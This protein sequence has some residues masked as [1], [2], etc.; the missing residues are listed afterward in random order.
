MKI[1]AI[2]RYSRLMTLLVVVVALVA[3]ACGGSS[4]SWLAAG[5]ADK[6]QPTPTVEA[7]TEP[8]LAPTAIATVTPTPTVTATPQPTA[9]PEPTPEFRSTGRPSDAGPTQV[10]TASRDVGEIFAYD[11]PR[12]NRIIPQYEYLNGGSVD[13]PLT[14]ST[15]WTHYDG[16]LSMHVVE[17]DEDDDWIKVLLPIRPQGSSAWIENENVEWSTSDHYVQINVVTNSVTVWDGDEIILDGLPVVTGSSNTP[18]PIATSYIDEI[19][20]SPS[21]VLGPWTL[22]LALFSESH[23]KFSGALPKIA[24]HGWNDNSVMGQNLSNGCIRFPNDKIRFLAEN[25]PV[26]TRVDIIST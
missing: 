7:V 23:N 5:A 11:A 1:R 20:P 13:Y 14:T 17:G 6:I 21:S 8:V 10:V 25:V 9:T 16:V 26:G 15:P 3:T 24:L 2:R 12:G 19:M 18:T 22:T 4:D